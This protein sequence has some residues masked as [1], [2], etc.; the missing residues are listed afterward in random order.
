MT[1]P[2]A[3]REK[4][5]AA[6]RRVGRNRQCP[7]SD[8]GL[9]VAKQV[10]EAGRPARQRLD[11]ELHPVGPEF[12]KT[13][14]VFRKCATLPLI[15][16][17]HVLA[18]NAAAPGDDF[19]LRGDA[20]NFLEEIAH[21]LRHIADNAILGPPAGPAILI[22]RTEKRIDAPDSPSL[23][24]LDK[25]GDLRWRGRFVHPVATHPE[26]IVA[27]IENGRAGLCGSG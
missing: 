8:R 3:R 19:D 10:A 9:D 26:R 5:A 1:V 6:W 21:L 2:N 20:M 27:P 11:I 25:S 22:H 16:Q 4:D 7:V 24:A 23:E 17:P 18:K 15:L 13:P 12:Y 14:G